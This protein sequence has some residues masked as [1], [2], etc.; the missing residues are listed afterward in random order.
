M[1]QATKWVGEV[2]VR[3]KMLTD[4]SYSHP[5]QL[6]MYRRNEDGKLEYRLPTADEKSEFLL[7]DAW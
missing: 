6:L 5:P 2:F 7:Q 3:R 4:G 1:K